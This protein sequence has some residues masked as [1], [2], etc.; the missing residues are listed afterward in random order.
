MIIKECQNISCERGPLLFLTHS[1]PVLNMDY[2]REA[3]ALAKYDH[4]RA[5]EK[6]THYEE[7]I[8]A[9]D[10]G[11]DV[12]ALVEKLYSK[13]KVDEDDEKEGGKKTKRKV[14]WE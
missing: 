10:Q 14:S 8:A 3:L 12:T 9:R 13:K 5:G 1:L 4:L 2:L 7:L 6:V 11:Q